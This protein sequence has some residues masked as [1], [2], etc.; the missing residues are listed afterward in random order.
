MSQVSVTI[1]GRQYRMACEDGQES[2]LMQLAKLL[3]ERIGELRGKFGEVGDSRLTVMAALTVADQLSEA[4]QKITNIENELAALQDARV[5]A[6]EHA[7]ATETA[8]IAALNA[9]AERIEGLTRNL[10]QTLGPG[11]SVG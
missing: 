10:N 9:A 2:H 6:A 11:V 3:D 7:Q 1:N 8:I 5:V 4:K